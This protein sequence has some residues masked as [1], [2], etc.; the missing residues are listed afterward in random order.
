M[1]NQEKFD[2]LSKKQLIKMADLMSDAFITHENW[3]YLIPNQNKRKNPVGKKLKLSIALGF[4]K[5]V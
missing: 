1:S 4:L 2:Q 3:T 5:W